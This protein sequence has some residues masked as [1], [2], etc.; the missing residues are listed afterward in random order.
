M[1][2]TKYKDPVTGEWVTVPS[3]KVISVVEYEGGD[4]TGI[5]SDIV[6]EAERVVSSIKSKMG[7]NSLT[8]IAMSDNHEPGASETPYDATTTENIRIGNLNAGQGARLI[9]QKIPLDF[10]AHLGDMAWGEEST[11]VYDGVATIRKVRDSIAEV[12][13]NNESFLTP[14]NHDNLSYGSITTGEFLNYDMLSALIGTYRYKDFDSKKVRV[15]CLNTADNSA[16]TTARECISGQ[17]LQWFCEAL[18]LSAKSDCNKWGIIILSHHPLDWNEARHAGNVLA[19]YLEGGSY[20]NNHGGVAVSYNFSGKNGA[21]IIAQFHGHLH[22]FKVDYINDLRSGSPVPTTVKRVAIPTACSERPNTYGNNGTTEYYG[23]EFGETANY[24]KENP[25][26]GKNTAFCVVSIDLDEKVIYADCFGAGYDRIVSYGEKEIVT[27][28]VTNNLSNAENN[29]GS[30]IITEGADYSAT[31][32]AKDGYTLD[33]VTVTMGGA[34]V[35]VNNGV[36]NIQS[37]TGDIVITATATKNAPVYNVTNQVALALDYDTNNVY[38]NGLGYKD[39][40]RISTS[41]AKYEGTESGFTLT[42]YI[43][44]TIPATGLPKPIYVR[45]LNWTT[46]RNTRLY[47]FEAD[48]TYIPAVQ[49]TGDGSGK[50]LIDTYFTREQLDTDYWKLTPIANGNTS[51]LVAASADM[52]ST[53]YI[54]FSLKGSGEGLIITLDEPIE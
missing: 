13:L 27:Y 24:K 25:G 22:N 52:K 15:I 6:N 33:S 40:Y 18:D 46:D 23:I 39:G 28:S 31:I 9:S 1:S 36:I 16:N 42:G 30:T 51:Q 4:V 3:L 7:N 19:A 12:V 45:G 5:P 47:F 8:F 53:V 35:P 21:K 17:Q 2:V 14:G 26:T 38:N 11:S 32:T 37:V 43:P 34:S 29:N 49:I 48:K 50:S 20:S 54:R 41:A 44:Y 10:F